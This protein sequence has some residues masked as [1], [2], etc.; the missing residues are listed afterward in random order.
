M[1]ILLLLQQHYTA[2]ATGSTRINVCCESCRTR[3]TY[4]MQRTAYVTITDFGAISEQRR[5]DADD[6][7]EDKLYVMLAKE[8]D[9]VPCPQC[10]DYSPK[11]VAHLKHERYAFL[12]RNQLPLLLT[13]AL[14]FVGA[15][16]LVWLTAVE[17]NHEAVAHKINGIAAITAV[18]ILLFLFIFG[19]WCFR[20]W[21]YHAWTRAYD[22]NDP[23]TLEERLEEARERVIQ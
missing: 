5:D 1:L 19:A 2:E 11:S 23:A 15:V 10:G 14:T 6:M 16:G 20:A 9:D 22:P 21:A 13:S 7:A 4:K 17:W 12:K 3:Y 18:G 8:V